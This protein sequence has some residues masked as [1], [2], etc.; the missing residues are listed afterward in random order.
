MSG[1]RLY[2]I[3]EQYIAYL[4]SIDNRVQWN[5]GMKR[6]YVGIVLSLNGLNYYVPLESPKPG[7]AKLKSGSVII[8]I[9]GGRLGIMGFNNMI[10]VPP[11]C[12]IYFDISKVEDEKYKMLLYNQLEFCN[13]NRDVITRRAEYVYRKTTSKNI[14]Y[15]NDICCNFKKLERKS[16]KYDPNWKRDRR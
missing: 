10:P 6:P 13:K 1:F 12:L 5:K 7:H 11:E 2:H 9:D 16:R 4:N 15:Y 14:P 3:S 8:K